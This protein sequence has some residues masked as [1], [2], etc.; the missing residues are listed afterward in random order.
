DWGLNSLHMGLGAA[1]GDYNNDGWVDLYITSLGPASSPPIVGAHRLYR[2]NGN[3]TF[4]SVGATARVNRTSTLLPDGLGACWGDY[5][6]DGDLD[7]AVVGWIGGSGG[8]RLFRN[9]SSGAFTDVTLSAGVTDLTMR[10]FSPRLVDMN[11]D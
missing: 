1:V 2:N 4:T 7:L 10:G 6:L 3:S 9:N 11:S 8:N 5:D